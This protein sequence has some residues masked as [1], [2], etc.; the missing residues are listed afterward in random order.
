MLINIIV[1]AIVTTLLSVLLRQYKAELAICV[2]IGGGLVILLIVAPYLKNTIAAINS[3]AAIGGINSDYLRLIIRVIAVAYIT[4]LGA[5]VARDAGEGA[6]AVK[7]E[8]GGK[9][10][11]FSMC[12]PM[13]LALIETVSGML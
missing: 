4:E 10:I 9:L 7:V 11:I 13:L 2:S 12:V 8:L 1:I 3:I 5:G 6:L